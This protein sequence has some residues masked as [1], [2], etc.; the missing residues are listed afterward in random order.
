MRSS[1]LHCTDVAVAWIAEFLVLASS[2]FKDASLGDVSIDKLTQLREKSA[3]FEAQVR[4]SFKA[5]PRFVDQYFDKSDFAFNATLS[6]ALLGALE[7]HLRSVADSFS[8][9]SSKPLS[10]F[11][12][13][14][15]I[16]QQVLELINT[17]TNI[18]KGVRNLST[19][20]HIRTKPHKTSYLPYLLEAPLELIRQAKDIKSAETPA[21]M[22][23]LLGLAR[24]I[25]Q[26]AANMSVQNSN[27]NLE[28]IYA[29]I[30]PAWVGYV[31]T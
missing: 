16:A 9:I 4:S 26:L 29:H 7:E 18:T 5:N 19:Q 21:L 23:S 28:V 25:F 14:S 17:Y 15:S 24:S 10:G 6:E 20:V 30:F 8:V 1:Q 27:P 13:S 22:S 11:D 3:E 12:A 2:T 31:T